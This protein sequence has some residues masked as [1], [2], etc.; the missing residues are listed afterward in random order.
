[1]LEELLV[2]LMDSEPF[3]NLHNPKDILNI[4]IQEGIED[5]GG[6]EL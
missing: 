2:R 1:M 5:D 3:A 6:W 4:Q